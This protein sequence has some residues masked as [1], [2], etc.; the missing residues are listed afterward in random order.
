[1][2]EYSRSHPEWHQRW[3]FASTVRS[4]LLALEKQSFYQFAIKS[5]ATV[6]IKTPSKL[7]PSDRELLLVMVKFCDGDLFDELSHVRPCCYPDHMSLYVAAVIDHV[8][9][10]FYLRVPLP[11]GFTFHRVRTWTFMLEDGFDPIIFKM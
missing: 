6:S 2:Q 4:W 10:I 7:T 5:L 9:S 1:M 8:R 3:V 11:V